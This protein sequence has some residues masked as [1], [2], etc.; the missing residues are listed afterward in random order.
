MAGPTRVAGIVHALGELIDTTHTGNNL[1]DPHL[2][3]LGSL[4][5]KDNVILSALVLVQILV[6][7]A[8]AKF[9]GAAI[10]ECKY[11]LRLVVPG[12]S[13][14]LCPQKIDMVIHQ[15]R[16]GAAHNQYLYA[17]SVGR[18][19]SIAQGKPLCLISDTPA[20]ATTTGTTKAHMLCF[21]RQKLLLLL[22]G[23]L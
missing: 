9:D 23:L 12:N 8:V 22:T 13:M 1:L 20:L 14:Q 4:I 6:I 5:Q 21:G 19:P 10:R 2:L 11:L 3:Q 7:V 18:R 15:L 16:K 17:V